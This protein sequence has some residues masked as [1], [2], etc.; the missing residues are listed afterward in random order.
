MWLHRLIRVGITAAFYMT[1]CQPVASGHTTEE[2]EKEF[3]EVPANLAEITGMYER[4]LATSNA[5]PAELDQFQKDLLRTQAGVTR[6][7]IHAAQHEM[8]LDYQKAQ[9]TVKCTQL[10]ER[11][12]RAERKAQNLEKAGKAKEAEQ[13]YEQ[14]DKAKAFATVNC[15]KPGS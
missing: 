3:G 10:L 9:L 6:E 8:L 13:V 4:A 7:K 14:L 1:V 2:L 12:P 11:I 15:P 5:E